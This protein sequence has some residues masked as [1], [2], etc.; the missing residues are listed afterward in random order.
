MN[1]STTA[2]GAPPT[3]KVKGRARSAVSGMIGT[4]LEFFDLQLYGLAAALVFGPLFFSGLPPHLALLSSFATYAVGFLARPVGALFFGWWGDRKGRKQVLVIT[5][6][7]MGISTTAIGLLPTSA[8]VGVWAPILLVSL[9]LL[10]GFGAGAELSGASLLLAEF[11]NRNN[12]GLFSSLVC[13]GT[14]TGTLL[15]SGVWLLVSSLP[16]E[17]LYSWGWRIPFLASI[18]VALFALWIRKTLSETPVFEAV[19]EST[20]TAQ[21]TPVKD[22]LQHGRRPFFIALGL[23][24]GENGPSYLLQAFLVGYIVTG[25][26][27]DAWVGSAAV[28]IASALAYLTIPLAGWLS[29]RLGR[30]TMY[31]WLSGLLVVW[32]FPSWWLLQMREPWIVFLVMFVGLS[33]GVLSLYAVQSSYFP[34]LFGTRYRYVGLAM[35]KEIGGILAGG[36]APLV[37]TALLSAFS[38]SWV[39]IA[40]YMFVL[41]SI[42][43][44]TTFL[45]PETK[46]RDLMLTEDAR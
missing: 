31:R 45:A 10:Q 38:G 27:M 43:F 21:R 24:I 6:A 7:L 23:R 35:G 12:R 26:S 41:S 2:V 9:R 28:L 36:I 33:L 17:A 16:D 13:L 15:A 40:V 44:L 18:F 46:G 1:A 37:A 11:S 42:S 4:T 32:S 5:V 34:E 25:L 3:P 8:Q 19:Q 20:D 30:R 14:N 29:D 39:P 22:L